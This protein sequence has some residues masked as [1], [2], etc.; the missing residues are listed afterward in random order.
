[1]DD[2]NPANHSDA[3][4]TAFVPRRPDAVRDATSTQK[5][6]SRDNK[7][8]NRKERAAAGAQEKKLPK[9]QLIV[10]KP[11]KDVTETNST[12]YKI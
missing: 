8:E 3:L 12:K 10:K 7:T 4:A 6:S 2:A 1:M 9:S 5:T 11:V